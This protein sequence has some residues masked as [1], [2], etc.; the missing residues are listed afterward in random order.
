MKLTGRPWASCSLSL[1]YL[2]VLLRKENKT[3]YKHGM[4]PS[5]FHILRSERREYEKV[6]AQ[7]N[8]FVTNI[9]DEDV[10]VLVLLKQ[11]M[12]SYV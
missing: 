1:T 7:Y 10:C 2:T 6:I 11:F 5:T 3:P 8:T 4:T 9:R 12:K